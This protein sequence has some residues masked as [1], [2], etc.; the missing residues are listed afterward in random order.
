VRR[1]AIYTRIS[2]D[3]S[4]TSF[5]PERQRAEAEALCAR[6]GWDVVAHFEDRDRS[7]FKK[8]RNERP[9]LLDLRAAVEAGSVDVVVSYSIARLARNTLDF[10]RLLGWLEDRGVAVRCVADPV[11]TTSAAGRLITTVIAALAQMESEMISERVTSSHRVRRAQGR[12][13]HARYRHFGYTREGERVPAEAELLR[14]AAARVMDGERATAVARWLTTEAQTTGGNDWTYQ[15]L[16]ATLTSHRLAGR[17]D[18][19]TAG[20]WEPILTD[21][22]WA[23]LRTTIEGRVRR[24]ERTESMLSGLVK[25]GVCGGRMHARSAG[26][27]LVYACIGHVAVV[28]DPLHRHVVETVLDQPHLFEHGAGAVGDLEV[29]VSEAEAKLVDLAHARYVEGRIGD[30]EFDAARPVL[31]E[32]L[33]RAVDD[34]DQARVLDTGPLDLV[35]WYGGASEAEQV[36]WLRSAIR[37]VT[38]NPASRRGGRFDPNRVTVQWSWP[39]LMRGAAPA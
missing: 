27:N 7:A 17:Y 19:G 1:A 6:E 34:L 35:E 36:R 18:D 16:N 21:E 12:F 26:P 14:E 37:E 9:G 22:E 15:A 30:A 28:R 23:L 33:D 25:C 20:A 32:R 31:Q 5:S 29:A 10:H 3:P 39:V 38:V 24:Q 2:F 13:P 4:G 8:G 11:D